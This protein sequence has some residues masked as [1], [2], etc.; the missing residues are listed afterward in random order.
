MSAR[1]WSPILAL[2]LAISSGCSVESAASRPFFPVS[3]RVTYRG[4][5]I[6]K[7]V[8]H[9]IPN[10][11]G[12]IT[13]S[14]EIVDGAIKNVTSRTLGDG[15]KPGKYRVSISILDETDPEKDK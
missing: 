3:G 7:G 14:G 9:L 10:A 5:P 4:E 13:A 1:R 12:G 8:I 15:A 2:A 6:R 11:P